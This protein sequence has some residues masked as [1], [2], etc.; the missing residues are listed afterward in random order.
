MAAADEHGLEV[1]A[2]PARDLMATAGREL[3]SSAEAL[4]R[5]LTELGRPIGPPWRKDEKDATLVAWLALAWHPD[6]T[7]AKA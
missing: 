4:R 1:F 6:I 2:V 7:S 3:G 5:A